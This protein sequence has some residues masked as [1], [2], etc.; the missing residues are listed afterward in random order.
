MVTSYSYEFKPSFKI[1]NIVKGSPAE[2]SGLLKGDVILRINGESIY[3]FTLGDV[4]EKFQ[5][6]D[7]AKIKMTVQRFV[8]KIRVEFRLKRKI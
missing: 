4:I 6:K 1:K 5:S 2:K 3:R 7:N 8:E